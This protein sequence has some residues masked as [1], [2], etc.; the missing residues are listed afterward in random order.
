LV[1]AGP[2]LN[3]PVAAGALPPAAEAVLPALDPV[4]AVL[5][6]PAVPLVFVPELLSSV[7]EQ[8][9]TAAAS[10]HVVP[11]TI[12]V[13]CCVMKTTSLSLCEYA[14]APLRVR[15]TTWQGSAAGYS[16]PPP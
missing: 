16:L 5:D 6:M 3:G 7:L 11:A 13:H 9:T 4:G 1:L 15:A 8:P 2:Q 10:N 14:G 12:L